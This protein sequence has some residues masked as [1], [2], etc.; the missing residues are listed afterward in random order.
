MPRYGEYPA[1][2]S[3]A[4][5]AGMG[6]TLR[7]LDHG[8]LLDMDV[9]AVVAGG[10]PSPRTAAV[11]WAVLIGELLRLVQKLAEASPPPRRRRYGELP[12]PPSTS[13]CDDALM[14]SVAGH[15]VGLLSRCGAVNSMAALPHG[16]T[17][18]PNAVDSGDADD[19][20][21]RMMIALADHL[22]GQR[23]HWSGAEAWRRRPLALRLLGGAPL[24][25][26]ARTAL[27]ARLA[28]G[29]SRFG[30]ILPALLGL[31]LGQELFPNDRS[32]RLL[33]L[34]PPPQD[35]VP[36]GVMPEATLDLNSDNGGN[37]L[38]A[39]ILLG[40]LLAAIGLL[41]W[42]GSI[43]QRMIVHLASRLA[44]GA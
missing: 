36:A 30:Q 31:G 18:G 11:R 37:G 1:G 17:L 13:R 22:L 14:G 26:A 32:R 25:E 44:G 15:V 34:L 21:T 8:L 35:V 9:G 43:W 7:T 5:G 10:V 2:S 16:N 27:H 23:G 28:A 24:D 19:L 41:A 20:E 33:A 3:V 42:Q 6:N 38:G 39:A 12:D 4:V 29:D 40:V